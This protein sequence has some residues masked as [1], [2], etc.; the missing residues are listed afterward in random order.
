LV[1]AGGQHPFHLHATH[2]TT[3]IN[4]MSNS[5]LPFFSGSPGFAYTPMKLPEGP[6]Q[7]VRRPPSTSQSAETPRGVAE[8]GRSPGGPTTVNSHDQMSYLDWTAENARIM[9]LMAEM[10]APEKKTSSQAARISTTKRKSVAKN[11]TLTKNFAPSKIAKKQRRLTSELLKEDFFALDESER[12]QV[13][14]PALSKEARYLLFFGSHKNFTERALSVGLGSGTDYI[15]SIKTDGYPDPGLNNSTFET[16][17]TSSN[18]NSFNFGDILGN[19]TAAGMF[20]LKSQDMF[21]LDSEDMFN[22]GD[23][24]SNN[25]YQSS[26]GGLIPPMQVVSKAIPMDQA[27]QNGEVYE[28]GALL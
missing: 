27:P 5:N 6:Q 22:L 28:Y 3:S 13:L 12:L 7:L 11:P 18:D 8:M 1:A 4:T 20:D 9:P 14:L 17:N 26:A 24:Q 23:Y 16:Y 19:D 2:S 15:S 10:D 25:A 21:N